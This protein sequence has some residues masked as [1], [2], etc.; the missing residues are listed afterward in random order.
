MTPA[1]PKGIKFQKGTGKK[2][3]TAILP[4]G[5]KVHFGHRDYQHYRDSVPKKLGGGKWSHKD[6]LDPKRRT[7]YRKRHGGMICKDGVKCISKRYSPA[8]FS[9][10]FLW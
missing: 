1:L 5:K 3:Y 4:N 8:W 10:Y 7:N 2:K 6:H 9:Y